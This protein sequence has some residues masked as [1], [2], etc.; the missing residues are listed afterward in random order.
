MGWY[1]PICAKSRSNRMSLICDIVLYTAQPYRFL[2]GSL[3]KKKKKD[4]FEREHGER[5]GKVWRNR[6][7]EKSRLPTEQGASIKNKVC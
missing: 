1:I 2:P 7:R 4:L 6:G 3:K 5:G